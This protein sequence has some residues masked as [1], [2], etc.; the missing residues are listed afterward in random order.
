M[1]TWAIL[2]ILTAASLPARAQEATINGLYPLW[3]VTGELHDA[4]RA[5][6]GYQHAQLG[7]GPLQLETQ[8]YLDAYG[9]VNGE[10]RIRLFRDAAVQLGWYHA[11]AQVAGHEIGNVHA[12]N[13]VNPAPIDLV[14]VQLAETF[15]LSPRLQ[16]HATATSL[17]EYSP[18]SRDSQVS[19]GAAG[20]LEMR[21]SRHFAAMAHAGV[22]G[23]PV[24]LQS[25]AGLSFA[26]RA[27]FLDLRAGYAARYE[28]GTQAG[29]VLFDGAV[30][31]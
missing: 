8:P 13:L 12:V 17:L 21:A 9:T 22:E 20:I 25:H 1:R 2:G 30:V 26:F 14:P 28:N 10:V 24:S 5:Q 3:E 19:F 18:D 23:A 27:S 29:V 11:P 16:L 15:G 7:L 4:G 6:V 31:F